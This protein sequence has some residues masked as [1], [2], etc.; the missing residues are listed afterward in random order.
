MPR[1]RSNMDQPQDYAGFLLTFEPQRTEH[2]EECLDCYGEAAESFSA[3]DWEFARREVVL[4]FRYG[5]HPALFGAVLMQRMHGSGGTGKLKMRLS[6]P[7]LFVRDI[8]SYEFE[9]ILPLEE[10]ISSASDL[11]RIS[12]H[13]WQG[14]I[15]VIKRC[16]PDK[17]SALDELLVMREY[18]RRLLGDDTRISRLTEQRDALGLCLDMGGIDRKEILRSMNMEKVTTARSTLDLLDRQPV[19][20]RSLVEHD[21]NILELT[22]TE[23]HNSA[24]FEGAQGHEVRV[25]VSD[26]TP[27]ET[28]LGVDL[29]IYQAHFDSF[30]LLQYK[31]MDSQG[32][33]A[34]KW[35]H[36]VDSQLLS[37]L[38]MMSNVRDA[39]DGYP[40]S[41]PALN[42]FRLNPDPFFFKFCE[43]TR[44]DARDESLVRGITM[45]GLHLQEFLELPEAKGRNGGRLVSYENCPRYFSNTEFISLARGGWIGCQ[46][47]GSELIRR[48]LDAREQGK[49]QM[50]AVIEAPPLSALNRGRIF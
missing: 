9:N 39:I 35:S 14:L 21:R 2:I 34:G 50:L 12:A 7:V 13:E 30:I 42:S 26:Q 45:S 3:V 16:R 48:V 15:A 10:R 1:K 32:S 23:K 5:K 40:S 33:G 43:R 24:R 11:R 4:L 37:Q 41:P 18:E 29:F 20:E 27:L 6:D 44:P 22:L 28:V 17:A 47:S 36:S 8:P 38:K 49:A 31:G 46:L 19:A 25:Y